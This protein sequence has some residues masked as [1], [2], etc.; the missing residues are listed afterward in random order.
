MYYI[1]EIWYLVLS[2]DH[3]VQGQSH[4]AVQSASLGTQFPLAGATSD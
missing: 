1:L 3:Y 4:S 2:A